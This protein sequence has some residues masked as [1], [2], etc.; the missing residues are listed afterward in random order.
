MADKLLAITTE[1]VRSFLALWQSEL[2]WPVSV[3]KQ[4]NELGLDMFDV[5]QVLKEGE[6]IECEKEIANGARMVID[7]WTCDNVHVIVEVWTELNKPTIRLRNIK[8]I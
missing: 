7:G 3:F 6:V 4:V 1:Y 2:G 8:V 5:L